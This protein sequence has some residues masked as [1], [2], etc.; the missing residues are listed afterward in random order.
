MNA[1]EDNPAIATLKQ[2]PPELVDTYRVLHADAKN[3]GTFHAF[4][5]G[6]AGGKIDYILVTPGVKVLEAAIMHDE[7]GGKYPSDHYP[8][9]A[10]VMW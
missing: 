2:G 8:V 3:V 6:T 1:A 7:R 5:G 10:K 9:R 4:K